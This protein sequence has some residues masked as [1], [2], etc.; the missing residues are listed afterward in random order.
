MEIGKIIKSNSGFYDVKTQTGQIVRTRARG[1]FRQQKIKPLVGDIIE[2]EQDYILKIKPR[3][4]EIIRPLIANVDQALIV[5]SAVQPTFSNNLLDRFLVNLQAQK[6]KPLIYLSKTDLTPPTDLAIIH[7]QLFYYERFGYQVFDQ[8]Q[9]S[10]L[11]IALSQFETV[12]TGQTGTGKSTLINRLLPNLKL[13]TDAIS[14]SLHRG[15]HTTRLVTLYP[16][17]DGLIADTPGFS[18]L[19]FQG[20][21]KELLPQLFVDFQYFQPFCKY[22]SCLHLNEPDCAVKQAVHEQKILASRYDNY[23]Q[24]QEELAQIRPVYQKISN[25][26][27]GK[28]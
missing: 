7:Q 23:C 15:K 24:F 3:K 13:K 20:I 21:T 9:M 8:Q 6:I 28:R 4:N 25:K 5:M 1:N 16:F 27:E 19:K 14:D 12:V 2:F 22:R 26:K 18:S 17:Q 10:E 11:K